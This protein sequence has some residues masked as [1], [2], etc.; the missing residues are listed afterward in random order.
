MN[1]CGQKHWQVTRAWQETQLS[2]TN[3]QETPGQEGLGAERLRCT[4]KQSQ[5]FV[6]RIEA[7]QQIQIFYS[8]G[9]R[10]EVVEKQVFSFL[11]HQPEMRGAQLL[12]SK[13]NKCSFL[14]P[15]FHL[16]EIWI[17]Y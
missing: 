17:S 10:T 7:F 9:S 8:L 3:T 4:Q 14:G 16:T 11:E 2:Q 5:R 12:H 1:V 6:S 13:P 15:N